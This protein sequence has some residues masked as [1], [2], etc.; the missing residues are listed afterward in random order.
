VPMSEVLSQILTNLKTGRYQN[1]AAVRETIVLPILGNLGWQIY[2]PETV[3]REYPVQ[4]R[5]VDYALF[6]SGHTPLPQLRQAT[7]PYII[8]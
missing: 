4:S 6:A 2:D 5:R 3:H 1:E 8:L 7:I